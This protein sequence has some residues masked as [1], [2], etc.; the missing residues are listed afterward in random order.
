MV[1]VGRV[2][3]VTING[4]VGQRLAAAPFAVQDRLYFLGRI[5]GV[6][7]RNYIPER[8]E[9]SVGLSSL[10]LIFSLNFFCVVN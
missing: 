6:K 10:F 8:P 4:L 9:I 1:M 7:L 2:F 5:A 3:F